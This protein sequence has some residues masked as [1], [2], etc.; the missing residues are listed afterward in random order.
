[1]RRIVSVLLE[2]LG[3][4]IGHGCRVDPMVGRR[5]NKVGDVE[6][7]CPPERHDSARLGTMVVGNDGAS[8]PRY[9]RAGS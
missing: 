4:P 2:A 8:A 9:S 1:M 7:E 3:R 5:A 6:A